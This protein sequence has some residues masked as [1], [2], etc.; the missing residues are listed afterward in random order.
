M[1]RQRRTDITGLKVGKLTVIERAGYKA[2]KAG[3]RES[4][5]LC[6]CDCGNTIIV[7]QHALVLGGRKSCGCLRKRDYLKAQS[8]H[9][10][11]RTRIYHIYHGML[12][13]CFNE[14]DQH[15]HLYG[16]RGIAVCEEWQGTN[17]FMNF[18]EWAMN[19]GYSES[20]TIDRIDV[21]GNYEPSNCR[22]ATS[23]E[24]ANN[25]RTNHRYLVNGEN[26]TAPQI[27]KKYGINLNTFMGRMYQMNLTPQ[28]AVDYKPSFKTITYHGE[29]KT[30][31]EWAKEKN[32]SPN[33]IRERL[34]RDYPIEYIFSKP[35]EMKR[36]SHPR[37][38]K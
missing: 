3:K 13:R 36:R 10:M 18:Y 21:N 34:R 8:I 4:L 24:Q 38:E 35:F 22:W 26:L 5:W 37:K 30:V 9:G 1:S 33:L 29:T 7:G 23:W 19:N 15:Y 2:D 32:I 12:D 11:S 14:K 31:S 27:S 6:K 17:G 28:E 25:R 16:E 20:L